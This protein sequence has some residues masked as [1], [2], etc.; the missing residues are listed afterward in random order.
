KIRITADKEKSMITKI[1]FLEAEGETEYYG[2]DLIKGIGS[3][4]MKDFYDKYL[5]KEFAFADIDGVDT[6]TGATMTTKGIV[7]AIKKAIAATK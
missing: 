1:E 4:K 7:S 5:V 2:A 6:S 3:G